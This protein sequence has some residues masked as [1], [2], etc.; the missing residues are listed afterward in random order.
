[1][2]SRLPEQHEVRAGGRNA[3][4]G[5]HG[6][7][8]ASAAAAAASGLSPGATGIHVTSRGAGRIDVFVVDVAVD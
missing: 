4:R 3:R 7:V 1:M 6:N 5:C 8:I 2:T